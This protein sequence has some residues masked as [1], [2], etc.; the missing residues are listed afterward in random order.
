MD[1]VWARRI[2]VLEGKLDVE[3]NIAP[4]HDKARI[5]WFQDETNKD[6]HSK[7]KGRVK[8]VSQG[9]LCGVSGLHFDEKD[10]LVLPHSEERC[11]TLKNCLLVLNRKE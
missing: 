10:S 6:G 5:V 2:Q 11:K 4:G 3:W 9:K 7:S 1:N 8:E